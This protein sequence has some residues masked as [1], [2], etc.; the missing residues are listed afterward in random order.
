MTAEVASDVLATG[1][2]SGPPSWVGRMVCE[3]GWS[4]VANERLGVDRAHE[5]LSDHLNGHLGEAGPRR[6]DPLLDGTPAVVYPAS[7]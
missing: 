5:L 6:W 2:R 1:R 3:C 4:L 7:G